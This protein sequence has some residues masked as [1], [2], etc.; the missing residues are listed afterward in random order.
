LK[1]QGFEAGNETTFFEGNH[2]GFF[3]GET[4][5][6]VIRPDSDDV[7]DFLEKAVGSGRIGRA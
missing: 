4:E 5:T 6:L 1:K 2:I 7:E 3:R